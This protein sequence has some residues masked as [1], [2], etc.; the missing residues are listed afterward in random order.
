MQDGLDPQVL[1]LLYAIGIR[2]NHHFIS[3]LFYLHAGQNPTGPGPGSRRLYGSTAVLTNR[4]KTDDRFQHTLAWFSTVHPVLA[5]GSVCI[6]GAML[7]WVL[8]DA[9]EWVFHFNR[10]ESSTFESI[11]EGIYPYIYISTGLYLA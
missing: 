7:Q 9:H 5:L 2:V 1:V 10:S 11:D 6:F 8:D 3:A 4:V